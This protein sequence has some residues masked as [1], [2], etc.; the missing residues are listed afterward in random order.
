MIDIMTRIR[1][2]ELY[3]VDL[4]DFIET[5]PEKPPF[6]PNCNP[7]LNILK[8]FDHLK[9]DIYDDLELL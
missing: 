2:F 5:H 7:F 6:H 4:I 3:N 8:L 1:I 9:K